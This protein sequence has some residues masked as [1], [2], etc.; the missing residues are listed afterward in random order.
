MLR[1]RLVGLALA[2]AAGTAAIAPMVPATAAS[3]FAG[4][5][6]T[7]LKP[8]SISIRPPFSPAA[9]GDSSGVIL[10]GCDGDT[11]GTGGFVFSTTQHEIIYWSN[12]KTTEL[13]RA[14]VSSTENDPD[15]GG[16]CP[17]TLSETEVSGV[18]KTDTTGSAPVLGKYTY[19]VCT[20]TA[21]FGLVGNEPGSGVK[22]G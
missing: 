2:L 6:C 22:I 3:A 18:V 19:E 1:P 9:I 13:G 11:G 7:S 17:P 8:F 15:P 14:S 21:Y 5:K 12:G 4:I 16:T 10:Q 20:N